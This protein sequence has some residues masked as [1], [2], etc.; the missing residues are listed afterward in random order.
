V[1]RRHH[2]LLRLEPES[3]INLI[4]LIAHYGKVMKTTK[5]IMKSTLFSPF[6]IGSGGIHDIYTFF[7]GNPGRSIATSSLMKPKRETIQFW[8]KVGMDFTK[9]FK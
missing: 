8:E 1:L 3:K 6:S 7:F 5:L 2:E 4:L 9:V